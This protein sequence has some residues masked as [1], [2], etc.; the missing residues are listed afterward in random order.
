MGSETLAHHMY[1]S[2]ICGAAHSHSHLRFENCQRFVASHPDV[3]VDA[4]PL[5]VQ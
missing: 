2:H 3:G 4:K 1:S 5:F